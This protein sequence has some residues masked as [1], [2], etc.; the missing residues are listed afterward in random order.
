M[1][2]VCRGIGMCIGI[3]HVRH[4][5]T[6]K[7][8]QLIFS[9]IPEPKSRLYSHWSLVCMSM[10]GIQVCSLINVLRNWTPIQSQCS[11]M[12]QGSDSY[13]GPIYV[14][15]DRLQWRYL[16]LQ[17]ERKQPKRELKRKLTEVKNGKIKVGS[18]NVINIYDVIEP[19]FL[20][21]ARL[22]CLINTGDNVIYPGPIEHKLCEIQ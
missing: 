8:D 9:V 2:L 18:H 19:D 7:A 14:S 12:Q 6:M 11:N 15:V 16:V 22:I 4:D 17:I 10:G 21:K 13:C 3:T 5:T 20:A 1:F